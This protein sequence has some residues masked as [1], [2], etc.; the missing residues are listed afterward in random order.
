MASN[1]ILNKEV[2]NRKQALEK[3]DEE[4][5]FFGISE[6]NIKQWFDLYNR[7]FY[8][9]SKDTHLY[10]I[11]NSIPYAYPDGYISPF[12]IELNNLRDQLKRI[13]REIDSHVYEHFYFK[14]GNFLM[15]S[16]HKNNPT[17]K[18]QE[19][20]GQVFFM[21]SGKKRPI[22]DYQI[23]LNLKTKLTRRGDFIDD[24]NFIVFVSTA[25]LSAIEASAPIN[26]IEDISLSPLEINIYPQTLAEYNE[27]LGDGTLTSDPYGVGAD[28]DES[29][30]T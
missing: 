14:N 26:S 25:T 16:Q 28:T 1:I 15:D 29:G 21:Q 13:Q 4:F 11:Q 6:F 19:G 9:M 27:E 12:L 7:L 24:Q 3:L 8:Q 5:N 30:R 10:F 20:T 22:T 23:Y 18:L 17:A 2:Y